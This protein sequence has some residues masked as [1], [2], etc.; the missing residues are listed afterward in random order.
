MTARIG[1]AQ[2]TIAFG[3]AVEASAV[4]KGLDRMQVTK[5]AHG[6]A[7][8]HREGCSAPWE[9]YQ[10]HAADEDQK[11]NKQCQSIGAK[12]GKGFTQVS[13]HTVPPGKP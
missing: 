10:S 11:P 2:Q 6:L 3:P 7:G 8:A 4:R 12:M 13:R 9:V 5:G 1:E